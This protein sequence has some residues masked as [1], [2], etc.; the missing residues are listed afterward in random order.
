MAVSSCGAGRL[1]TLEQLD[2]CSAVARMRHGPLLLRF[3]ALQGTLQ[4]ASAARLDEI[5][6]C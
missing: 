6:R 2:V 4:L 1:A 5:L 3:V